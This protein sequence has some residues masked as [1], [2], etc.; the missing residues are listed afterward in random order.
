V[1]TNARVYYTTRAATG[2]S[3][4][5]IPHALTGRRILSR[6][7][8]IAPRDCEL[9]SRRHCE[10]RKRRSNPAFFLSAKKL[11]CFRLHPSSYGG[12]VA[13]LAM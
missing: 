9:I 8:R 1:V 11:D 12:Q 4:P 5:G 2:A 7:G 13:S 3:A 10:E 6:L